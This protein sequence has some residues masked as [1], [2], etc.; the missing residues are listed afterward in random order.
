[1]KKEENYSYFKGARLSETDSNRTGVGIILGIV[2]VFISLY[3]TDQK[4]IRLLIITIFA[5]VGFFILGPILF[6]KRKS[7]KKKENRGQT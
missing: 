5:G 4:S 2:G 7:A 1:M 6:K 3:V